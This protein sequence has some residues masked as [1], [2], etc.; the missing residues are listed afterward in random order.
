MKKKL[1]K[2]ERLKSV[3]KRI[4]KYFA[5]PD[6]PWELMV[7]L[8][9]TLLLIN[10]FMT[11]LKEEA[12][13]NVW[14]FLLIILVI[15][16]FWA[17]IDA[18]LFIFTAL[19]YRGHYNKKI[20]HIRSVDS[21]SA[22]DLIRTELEESIISLADEKIKRSVTEVLLNEFSE[23]N[24]DNSKATAF[25]G[26]Y[27]LGALWVVFFVMLPSV[28]L[29]PIFLITS[30]VNWALAVSNVIGIIAFFSFGY[31]LASC[32]NWNKIVTG[33]I[34]AVAGFALVAVGLLIGA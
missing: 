2:L 24:Y 11:S 29:L 1:L 31:K 22:I 10:Y 33:L 18:F 14:R 15:N 7:G 13:D 21:E 32:T 20:E 3:K 26:N 25:F 12:G 27:I 17:S 16:L 19:L 30:S 5:S 28:V 23:G 6:W 9:V 8:F 34:M 4:S